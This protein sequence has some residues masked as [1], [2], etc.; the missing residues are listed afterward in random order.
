MMDHLVVWVWAAQVW[1]VAVWVAAVVWED[2]AVCVVV[3][4]VEVAAV[5]WAVWA[6]CLVV[7]FSDYKQPDYTVKPLFS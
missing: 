5:V 1:V 6:V 2:Q 4:A 3:W 7:V